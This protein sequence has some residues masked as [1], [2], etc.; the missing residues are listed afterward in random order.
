MKRT[1]SRARPAA[2][3]EA[4]PSEDCPALELGRFLPYRLHVTAGQVSRLFSQTYERRFGIGI[5]EWRV[6][7]QLGENPAMPTQA[8]IERTGMDPV[9]VSRAV[10]RL[11]DKGLAE[12]RPHP[13]DQRSQLLGLSRAGRA[14]Y[15]EIVPRALALEAELTAALTPAEQAALDGILTKLRDRARSLTPDLGD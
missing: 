8:V 7:A 12:R 13:S 3:E 10:T 4:G 6:L 9:K 1:A 11:V 2:P 5:P 14:M 15:R